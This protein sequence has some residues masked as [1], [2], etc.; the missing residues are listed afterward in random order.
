MRR[1]ERGW[2]E[3]G[4]GKEEER[5]R[6]CHNWSSRPGRR[7]RCAGEPRASDIERGFPSRL[8]GDRWRRAGARGTLVKSPFFA[9]DLLWAEQDVTHGCVAEISAS[10]PSWGAHR[11]SRRRQDL[12]NFLNAFSRSTVRGQQP[13]PEAW[14]LS[15]RRMQ[16]V[17]VSQQHSWA[18][19]PRWDDRWRSHVS[20]ATALRPPL[21]VD[22]R[23]RQ[24][25]GRGRE[26]RRGRCV[27]GGG[28]RRAR[29]RTRSREGRRGGV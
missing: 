1:G 16:R 27:R 14:S 2:R 11:T 12:L 4:G 18:S 26:G 23:G 29:R 9:W 3:E 20:W 8:S 24:G 15:H 7:P 10:H 13:L 6:R 19:L 17:V 21:E 28:E 22:P 25:G 5:G